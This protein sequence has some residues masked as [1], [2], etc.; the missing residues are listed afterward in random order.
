MA[1]VS[2]RPHKMRIRRTDDGSYDGSG[3][4]IMGATLVSDPV[5]CRF[6][7]NGSANTLSFG[8]GKG[9]IYDYVVYANLDC[10]DVAYGDS[11][12]L[13]DAGGDKI[14]VFEVKGVRRGQLNCKIWV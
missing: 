4:Y 12:E 10:P 11:V 3:N 5:P 2:F 13:Y 14:G 9:Y 1:G 8:D 7:Q 6:E